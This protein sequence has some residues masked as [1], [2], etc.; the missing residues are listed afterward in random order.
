MKCAVYIRVSTDKEEQRTSL[1]NQQQFFYNVMTEKG[2]ELYQFYVDVESGTSSKKRK[3]LLQLIEDAKHRKFDVILSKELSRLAR[4][5]K[6]SYEIKEIA[7]NNRIHIITFDNAIN[8]VDNNSNMF[9][10]YAWIYEQESQR[11]SERIKIALTTKAKRGEYKGS[12]PPYG[13]KLENKHLFIA[14]DNTPDI[15]R[16]IYNK[17]ICGTGF[18]AIARSLSKQMLPTPSTVAQKSNKSTYWHG[19]TIKRMLSN[20]HYIGDLV[21]GREETISVTS[22]VRRQINEADYIVIKDAHEAIISREQFDAVQQLMLQ[23]K[24][25][26]PKS[27]PHLFTNFIYCDDCKSGLWYRSN[28]KGYI[29]GSYSKHGRIACSHHY[30]NEDKLNIRI[31]EDLNRAAQ[32]IQHTNDMED[33]DK[34]T[35]HQSK[36][37]KNKLEKLDSALE[38][39]TMKKRKYLELLS[40]AVLAHHEYREAM[41]DL[42]LQSEELSV[43]KSELNRSLQLTT[44][45]IASKSHI[46]SLL[47]QAPFTSVTKMLLANFVIRID[48]KE[49]GEV[50]IQYQ[51]PYI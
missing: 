5:G 12:I 1:E 23:R 49:N 3:S 25:K 27:S 16:H 8:S 24:R 26:R 29:C 32:R 48:V 43:K 13:Y 50:L 31:L 14:A 33:L 18:D 19:S 20:P 45:N 46:E 47:N 21:Q 51:S 9:G 2:W 15:V 10:L 30:V 11:T 17:Y 37:I 28:R 22:N 35:L 40:S 44:V 34:E 42:Y 36:S 41:N 38:S 7:E 6:L 4:N 39:I